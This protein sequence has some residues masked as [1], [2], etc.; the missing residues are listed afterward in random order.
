M[1]RPQRCAM[2]IVAFFHIL[3]FVISQCPAGSYITSEASCTQC[4]GGT[5][6]NIED[7]TACELCPAGTTSA[8][9]FSVTSCLNCPAGDYSTA[10]G[11]PYDF[12]CSP[13]EQGKYSSAVGSTGCKYCSVG[14]Y[15]NSLGVS[16][17]M[18]CS[19]GTSESFPSCSVC[20]I[21]SSAPFQNFSFVDDYGNRMI[22]QLSLTTG[23]VTSIFSVSGSFITPNT[24]SIF[25]SNDGTYLFLVMYRCIASIYAVNG[26]IDQSFSSLIW[27]GNCN[28]GGHLD[29]PAS[30][31]LFKGLYDGTFGPDGRTMYLTS[32]YYIR[33]MDLYGLTVQTLLGTGTPSCSNSPVPFAN[34]QIDQ[35]QG[36]F[37]SSSGNFLLIIDYHAHVL[38][39]ADLVQQMLSV[40]AGRCYTPGFTD[41]PGNEALFNSPEQIQVVQDESFVLVADSVNCAIR[42]VTLGAQVMVSTIVGNSTCGHANGL[43]TNALIGKVMGMGLSPTGS[44]LYV[45]DGNNRIRLMDLSVSPVVVSDFSGSG[46]SGLLDGNSSMAMYHNPVMIRT[47]ACPVICPANYYV[48]VGSTF[49]TACPPNS[50]AAP[51]AI[52]CTANTGY[53]VIGSTMS[54]IQTGMCS[55]CLPGEYILVPCTA[56][57]PTVCAPCQAGSTY[58]TNI[59]S[60]SCSVCSRFCD[61]GK[62][63]TTPCNTT[64]NIGCV[65]CPVG[66]YAT[67]NELCAPCNPGYYSANA[68]GTTACSECQLG[69]YS[70]S[71]ASACSFCHIG[72]F[73]ANTA[74]TECTTCQ[75]GSSTSGTG[76]SV[77]NSCTIGAYSSDGACSLCASGTFSTMIDASTCTACP[78]GSF[79]A[80]QLGASSCS[81]CPIGEFLLAASVASPS[82]PPTA[83][84]SSSQ[85]MGALTSGTGQFCSQYLIETVFNVYVNDIETDSGV[86]IACATMDSGGNYQPGICEWLYGQGCT[87]V[88]SFSSAYEEYNTWQCASGCFT[89]SPCTNGVLNSIFTGPGT[90]GNPNSCPIACNPG[91]V[92]QNGTCNLVGNCA[93]CS[94]GTYSSS[95]SSSACLSCAGGTYTGRIGGTACFG[96]PS[97]TYAANGSTACTN[98]SAGTYAS[99]ANSPACNVCT[100]GWFSN[101]TSS[102]ACYVCSAGTYSNPGNTMCT[103]CSVGTYTASANSSACGPCTG[104]S[105]ANVT[106][107]TA[108]Y[109]C[110]AG[111]YASTG[112]S[113]CVACPMGAYL[114][115]SSGTACFGCPSGTYATGGASICSNCSMG[116][117]AA[118]GNSSACTPCIGG[119]VSNVTS[120]TVCYVCS[121]GTYSNPG[122]TMCTNCSIGTY[123]NFGFSSCVLCPAGTYTNASGGASA[124]MQCQVCSNGYYARGC[125][126]SG[127]GVCAK[128]NNT[129]S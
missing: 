29:G 24:Y 121:A 124:C 42:K 18:E 89:A 70:G 17:C 114:G 10:V 82:A 62:Y 38:Y 74:S 117:Y 122:S 110:V 19:P 12:G 4:A 104:G 72:T 9:D 71:G 99:S 46:V 11:Q 86:E 91:Y 43:G 90:I 126:G 108:C 97:G 120:A 100:G 61:Q 115:Q 5:Y 127:S 96:C 53:Y 65:P 94:A 2:F 63:Y 112:S 68:Q 83:T 7:S 51:R 21:P 109:V 64:N 107:A 59:N 25:M 102:T 34:A 66:S 118:S 8:G 58:S 23:M 98:C 33:T 60:I 75:A 45:A 41:G 77:C 87:R 27:A 123:A 54:A 28:V 31:A 26:I 3:S 32:L 125:G 103:N 39:F 92:L 49:C 40:I 36:I 69:M 56:S 113:A 80:I 81:V 73:A 116:T 22:R 16:A 101:A 37:A 35:P 88:G 44:L 48:I 20:A 55:P 14:T 105:F 47:Y 30:S 67:Y 15:S 84:G 95:A 128:C 1:S 52:T 111:S 119:S 50:I 13:C 76:S 93:N 57:S 106:R 85:G 79:T 129:F 78:S 6:S